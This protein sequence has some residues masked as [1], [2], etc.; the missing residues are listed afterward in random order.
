V[1]C[2][3]ALVVPD[4]QR[5]GD[6]LCSQCQRAGEAL[7]AEE[8]RDPAGPAG[9]LS[10]LT[11]YSHRDLIDA[12]AKVDESRFCDAAW[13]GVD[14]TNL[15]APDEAHPTI[16][17]YLLKTPEDKAAFLDAAT[18]VLLRRMDPQPTAAAA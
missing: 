3:A 12:I 5:C 8:D 10:G 13:V 9:R 14:A 16:S 11:Q 17:S 6:V 18:A 4:T 2:G 15:A 7:A 1:G